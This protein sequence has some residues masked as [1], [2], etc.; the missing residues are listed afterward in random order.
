MEGTDI[1]AESKVARVNAKEGKLTV[2]PGRQALLKQATANADQ[3]ALAA[4]RWK[5]AG[6]LKDGSGCYLA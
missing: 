3:P 4:I 2:C 1:I 6:L 5:Q